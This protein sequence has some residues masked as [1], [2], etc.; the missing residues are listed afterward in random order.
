MNEKLCG[1]F[2]DLAGKS[3][4]YRKALLQAAFLDIVIPAVLFFVGLGVGLF[5]ILLE[6]SSPGFGV[7]VGFAGIIVFLVCAGA[8]FVLTFLLFRE[9]GIFIL[10]PI[11]MII[12]IILLGAIPLINILAFGLSLVPWNIVA[13]LAHMFVYKGGEAINPAAIF[14]EF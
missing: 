4:N 7:L 12:L 3:R 13:A 6:S 1:E 2:C 11:G 8:W 10:I 5:F 14:K 9:I